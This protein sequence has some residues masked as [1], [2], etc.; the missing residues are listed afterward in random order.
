[1]RNTENPKPLNITALILA[2]G[3]GQ[4]FG[5]VDKG[6]QLHLRKPLIEHVIDAIKP[7]V[8]HIIISVNRNY[9]IYQQYGL[10]LV[11]DDNEL[12]QGPMAGIVAAIK[13]LENSRANALLLSPCDSPNLPSNYVAM[14]SDELNKNVTHIALAT[15]GE[16]RQNL[17]SLIRR[18]AWSSL[19]DFYTQGNRAMHQWYKK[20]GVSEVDFSAQA[21]CFTNINSPDQLA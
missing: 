17:H 15:D 4:R 8:D 7:Q 21:D 3:A 16:R 19:Y 10:E 12:H 18:E 5:G 20:V 14:L 6:L 9:P 11:T 1:M 2:G 13:V